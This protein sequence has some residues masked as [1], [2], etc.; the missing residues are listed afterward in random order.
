MITILTRLGQQ[1]WEGGNRAA[2]VALWWMEKVGPAGDSSDWG[3]ADITFEVLCSNIDLL[4]AIL[5]DA[6]DS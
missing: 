4:W 3:R 6:G 2:A 1:T 5:I